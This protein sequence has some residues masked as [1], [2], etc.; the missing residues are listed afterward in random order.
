MPKRSA[1]DLAC[2][3]NFG[4]HKKPRTSQH[5]NKENEGIP[6]APRTDYL[7]EQGHGPLLLQHLVQPRQYANASVNDPVSP[8]KIRKQILFL[9]ELT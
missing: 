9:Y 6:M 4:H 8:L 2:I 7:K 1:R 5:A 3:N